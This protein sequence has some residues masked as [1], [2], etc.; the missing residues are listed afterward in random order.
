V[1]PWILGSQRKVFRVNPNGVPHLLAVGDMRPS[2]DT[3]PRWGSLLKR[4]MYFSYQGSP[5]RVQAFAMMRK[6]LGLRA[7]TTKTLSTQDREPKNQFR[8]SSS[9]FQALNPEALGPKCPT[10]FECSGM[11]NVP[12]SENLEPEA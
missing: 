4:D 2:K 5:L 3:E 10:F 7:K 11:R 12:K 6:A 9:R 8:V 1:L